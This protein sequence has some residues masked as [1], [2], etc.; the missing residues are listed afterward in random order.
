DSDVDDDDVDIVEEHAPVEKSNVYEEEPS[1]EQVDSMTDDYDEDSTADM[2]LCSVVD[3]D[4]TANMSLCS[5]V[6]E[7]ASE[8]TFF[9][10]ADDSIVSTSHCSILDDSVFYESYFRSIFDA[11]AFSYSST[12]LS[13]TSL[14]LFDK[15]PSSFF[16]NLLSSSRS[17]DLLSSSPSGFDD[18]VL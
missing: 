8:S 13:D 15:L 16:A 4:S 1:E 11:S 14:A 12:D 3:D 9:D 6:K 5:V 17:F 10:N 18:T 7:I 2:S